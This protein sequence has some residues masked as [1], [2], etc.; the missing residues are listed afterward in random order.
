VGKVICAIIGYLLS[1]VL[2][3]C[4]DK[5]IKKYKKT[6]ILFELLPDTLAGIVYMVLIFLTIPFFSL[7]FICGILV[8]N[9]AVVGDLLKIIIT[10]FLSIFGCF[11]T[12]LITSNMP[13]RRK[14]TRR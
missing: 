4:F 5:L 13:S 3:Y 9:Y 1:C 14:N 8:Y 11:Y 2:M 6:P 12:T 10:I 7:Q